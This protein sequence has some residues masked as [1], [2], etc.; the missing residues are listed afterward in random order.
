MKYKNNYVI[1]LLQQIYIFLNREDFGN[2]YRIIIQINSQIVEV[3]RNLLY[4]IKQNSV[5]NNLLRD[6]LLKILGLEKKNKLDYIL[7][8]L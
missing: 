8:D 1:F 6:E 7:G 2:I 3:Y 4:Y 5:A